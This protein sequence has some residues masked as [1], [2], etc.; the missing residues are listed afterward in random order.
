MK[1]VDGFVRLLAVGLHRYSRDPAT[2]AASARLML[3]CAIR[4]LAA[5]TSAPQAALDVSETLADL[6][7]EERG[8]ARAARLG[9]GQ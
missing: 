7:R 8:A 1:T 3:S 9:A 5:E 4:L 2:R 6:A